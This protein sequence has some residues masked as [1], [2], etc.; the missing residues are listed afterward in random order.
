M[1]RRDMFNRPSLFTVATF[2]YT[3]DYQIFEVPATDIYTIECWGAQGNYALRRASWQSTNYPGYGAYIRGDIVLKSGSILF[4]YVGNGGKSGSTSVIS[5]N[6]NGGGA[7][8][9]MVDKD[10]NNEASYMGA[11]GG[12]TDIR[13][14]SG[15]WSD[16]ESLTSRIAVAAGGGG[17]V[18]YY[19]R[20]D[21]GHGGGLKG[22]LGGYAKGSPASQTAGGYN[23][24]NDRT[25][26]VPGSLGMGGR[27]GIDDYGDDTS[28]SA[29]GGS[30]YYG[31]PS[32]GIS[33]NAIQTGGGGSSFISGHPGCVEHDGY[34]FTN[35]LMIDGAGYDWNDV[36]GD[37]MNMPNPYGGEYAL[38]RGHSGPGFCRIS[39]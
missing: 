18:E 36:K 2:S 24:G 8:H 10:N 9:K 26:G 38:G 12:A 22:Y 31:G 11:G 35:T 30:G 14:V 7:G 25:N 13:I 23:T 5:S 29:G 3:G 15:Q 16:E 17:G 20:G 21:A 33:V 19:Y 37:L 1:R 6:Y 4:V 28:Y 32:G 39:V 27:Y 34:I